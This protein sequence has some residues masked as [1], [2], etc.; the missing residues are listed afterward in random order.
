MRIGEALAS[1]VIRNIILCF[2]A[3]AFAP[4]R[5]AAREPDQPVSFSRACLGFAASLTITVVLMIGLSA[6]VSSP[7]LQAPVLELR[8]TI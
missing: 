2:V 1:V 8:G 6:A 7:T 4:A 5:Q 3:A